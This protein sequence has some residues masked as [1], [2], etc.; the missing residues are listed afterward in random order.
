MLAIFNSIIT[1]TSGERER[2]LGVGIGGE[3]IFPK[4][5]KELNLHLEG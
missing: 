3:S 4:E 5:E 2:A 1:R